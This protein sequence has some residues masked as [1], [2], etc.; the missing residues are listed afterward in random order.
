[1]KAL[2]ITGIVL[3][4]II[5]VVLIL[6]VIAPKNFEVSRSL[7]VNAPQDVVFKNISTFEQ[8]NKWNPWNKL[9]PN[10]TVKEEGVDGTVGAKHSWK[11]NKDVGEGSMTLT[12]VEPNKGVEYALDFLKPFEAHNT[13]YMTMEAVEGGQKVTWGMKGS[14]PFPMNAMG[15]F[16]NMDKQIGKDFDEGLA[17]LKTM[18]ES[19]A[20]ASASTYEVKEVDWAEKNYLTTTRQTVKYQ[21]M[22]NFF[23]TNFGAM[24]K[25]IAGAGAT[26]GVPSGIYY[27]YDEANMNAD[28]VAAIPYEGKKVSS[29]GFNNLTLPTGKAYLIEYWGDYGKMKPA[30]DAMHAKLKEL[31]SENPKLVVEEYVTDPMNETDTA[32]WNTK[33]YFFADSKTQ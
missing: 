33:I 5:A 23:G 2:K 8:F 9:D 4:V 17:T 20:S 12:K 28:M 6:G 21:D 19:G 3:A 14:M 11:G 30:Y 13:A 10:Q 27:K 26:P 7:V 24:S 15:L 25:A 31:G 18:S 1:M 29:K 16:M 22:G 32:K